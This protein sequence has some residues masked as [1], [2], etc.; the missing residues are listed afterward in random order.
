MITISAIIK[1]PLDIVWREWTSVKAVRHWAF[2]SDDWAAEGIQNDVR[3]GGTIKSR[4][5]AKDGSAE[6]MYE[7]VYIAVEP[8]RLLAHSLGDDR[9]VEVRFEEVPEGVRI[10]QAFEPEN[11]NPEDVQKQGWQAYLDNFKKYVETTVEKDQG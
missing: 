11:E 7:G 3:V 4:N 5:F 1:A 9:N 10:E 6:F 8:Q 2:A